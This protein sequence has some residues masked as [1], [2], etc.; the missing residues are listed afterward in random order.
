MGIVIRQGIKSTLSSYFGVALGAFNLLFLLPKLLQPDQI[1]LIRVIQDMAFLLASLSQFGVSNIIDRFFPYFHDE[2][3]K[4]KGF[5]YFILLLPIPGFTLLVVLFFLFQNYWTDLYTQSSPLLVHFFWYIIPLTLFTVYLQVL[6]AYSRAVMRIIVPVAVRE[7]F[8]RAFLTIAVSL[9]AFGLI[10]FNG[11]VIAVVVSYF[12]GIIILL[13]YLRYLKILYLKTFDFKRNKERVLQILKYG[14]VIFL[15]GF[16]GVLS[17]RIDVIMLSVVSLPETGIFSIAFFMGTVIEIPR[18]TLSQISI[19]IIARGW[20]N[21]DMETIK[22]IYRKTSLTQSVIGGILLVLLISNLTDLFNLIPNS[23]IYKTGF[24]VVVIIGFS[25]FIDMV[26][27]VNTEIILTSPFY[28]INFI[29]SV[30]FGI[31]NILFNY[32]LIPKYGMEGAAIGTFLSYLLINSTRYIIIYYKTKIQP[33]T[34]KHL[35]V[36]LLGV[37]AFVSVL[38]I[39]PAVSELESLFIIA[40]RTAVVSVVIIG[41]VYFLKISDEINS[42][43]KVFFNFL[44]KV[45]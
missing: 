5:L 40:I 7:V 12:F 10:G 22:D 37:A 23:E 4:N 17:S 39:P 36:F 18:R 20:K 3:E 41:G 14:G 42:I 15:S 32:L 26:A 9:F 19:P 34:L 11:L 16:V 8:L 31:T 21:D 44:S 13:F 24:I 30:V 27:G 1:G 6:E 28:R 29:L 45:F 38:F 25:R 35:W 2:K 43:I 33:F